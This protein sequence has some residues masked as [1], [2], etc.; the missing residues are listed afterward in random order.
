MPE[1]DYKVIR[2]YPDLINLVDQHVRGGTSLKELFSD[3][4][5]LK[6]VELLQDF[7]DSRRHG[8][9]DKRKAYPTGW[10][11]S[12][13]SLPDGSESLAGVL[14]RLN[15]PKKN[16]RI[17]FDYSA[18]GDFTW[19]ECT[20]S[21]IR[22]KNGAKEPFEDR[23]V[24]YLLK[25]TDRSIVSLDEWLLL[26]V[27]SAW[28]RL[29]EDIPRGANIHEP[30]ILKDLGKIRKV[31]QELLKEQRGCWLTAKGI[32][33]HLRTMAAIAGRSLGGLS[34]DDL[35]HCMDIGGSL[36]GAVLQYL[37]ERARPTTIQRR[38]HQQLPDDWD[39]S[40]KVQSLKDGR[41]G[42]IRDIT[43]LPSSAGPMIELDDEKTMSAS[44]FTGKN[45][46]WP[47]HLMIVE[48]PVGTPLGRD[49]TYEMF[50][51]SSTQSFDTSEPA[52][53]GLFEYRYPTAPAAH[54][55]AAAPLPGTSAEPY[56]LAALSS[57]A[58]ASSSRDT[59]PR[60]AREPGDHE[61]RSLP[62]R[63]QPQRNKRPRVDPN[64]I[65]V[66]GFMKPEDMR[67]II[68]L[69]PKWEELLELLRV[70]LDGHTD[71][72]K[73]DPANQ[74]DI[75][76]ALRRECIDRCDAT[77]RP[78]NKERLSWDHFNTL[79]SKTLESLCL[80]FGVDAEDDNSKRLPKSKMASQLA[81]MIRSRAES[82]SS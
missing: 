36:P 79:S 21:N 8:F 48:Q 43:S 62:S 65:P 61:P 9:G 44:D 71:H 17:W 26:D 39:C 55:A 4:S 70:L 56:Y 49:V 58:G 53:E 57:P 12:D 51:G 25:C 50:A 28:T 77:K 24:E 38:R 80:K 11:G 27:D 20:V 52:P 41:K 7:A 30:W 64:P 66:T 2:R 29:R 69:G 60:R 31:V 40:A 74:E 76:P 37:S 73:G 34:G 15:L 13:D 54:I 6:E 23:D 22:F 78:D 1:Q 14:Q 63:S 68:Q 82:D 42:T 5:V 32:E 33:D 47:A 35:R 45:R 16:E 75:P 67:T 10:M 46:A 72:L 3:E 19:Y 18:S 81:A 59:P